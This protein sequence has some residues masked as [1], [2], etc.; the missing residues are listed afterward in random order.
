MVSE[1]GYS[2]DY[3]LACLNW[4]ASFAINEEI[5]NFIYSSP[6]RL[7]LQSS[8]YLTR[9]FALGH[10]LLLLH[11]SHSICRVHPGLVDLVPIFDLVFSSTY[12][13]C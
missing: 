7:G 8:R 1:S 12:K 9:R 6:L 5:R 3:D 13:T 4:K 11:E 10:S 2:R